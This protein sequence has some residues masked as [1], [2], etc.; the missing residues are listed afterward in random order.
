MEYLA[1]KRRKDSSGFTLMELILVIL[2]L[3]VLA[4]VVVPKVVDLQ[5]DA[6]TR[7]EKTFLGRLK[8]GLHMFAVEQV[9]NGKRKHYPIVQSPLFRRVMDKVPSNWTY[10]QSNG[11][12]VHTRNDGS[13]K[14]WYYWINADSSKYEIRT[15]FA[16]PPP[17][18]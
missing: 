8:S 6:E 1:G 7:V 13:T 9:A 15:T 3:G 5:S 18:P 17:P 16:A 2:I 11:K 12:I 4:A 10:S 14:A